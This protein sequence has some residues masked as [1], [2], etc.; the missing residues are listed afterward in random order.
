MVGSAFLA[1]FGVISLINGNTISIVLFLGLM[2]GVSNIFLLTTKYRFITR[3]I[4]ATIVALIGWSLVITGGQDATGHLWT[5]P[6]MTIAFAVLTMREGI[7]FGVIYMSMTS[8]FLFA[9]PDLAFVTQY[10][11]ITATRYFMSAIALSA[12]ALLLVQ[13]QESAHSQLK[14]QTVTDN[15]TGLFNR[16]VLSKQEIASIQDAKNDMDSYLLLID[17]DYFKHIND[18][19]GHAKGDDVLVILADILR[20]IIRARDFAIRWGG[21]EFLI[22]LK[23][24]PAPQAKK[25]AEK[26]K[27][28]FQSDKDL[29]AL[30]GESP[31]LSVG[32]AKLGR[33]DDF[34]EALK[35]ADTHLYTAK[36]QGR[37][38]VIFS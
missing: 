4:L 3:F 19:F 15:L 32:I 22:I 6:L 11:T 18:N 14:I 8:V 7:W 21:E 24:C 28:T 5:Y 33:L 2:A 17:I 31:T 25:V 29:I 1:S 20:T 30:L 34:S 38:R 16:A 13:T 23:A 10:E 37:N 36:Q 27:D 9:L 35:L 26:I 12:M